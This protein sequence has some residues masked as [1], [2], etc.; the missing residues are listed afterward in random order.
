MQREVKSAPFFPVEML[1]WYF[2]LLKLGSA[3]DSSFAAS[4]LNQISLSKNQHNCQSAASLLK[5]IESQVR[6]FVKAT[7]SS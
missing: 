2:V 4:L 7:T 3:H 1:L 6:L 5:Q